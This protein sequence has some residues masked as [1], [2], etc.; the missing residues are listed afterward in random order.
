MI[1]LGDVDSNVTHAVVKF[2]DDDSI[3]TVPVKQ[4]ELGECVLPKLAAMY[5]V[6]WMN[7]KRYAAE[8]IAV[9]E[10]RKTCTRTSLKPST[11]SND[12]KL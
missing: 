11:Y 9:G 12:V 2:L 6:K 5:D 10:L 7:R 8:V 3:C 1:D 4:I